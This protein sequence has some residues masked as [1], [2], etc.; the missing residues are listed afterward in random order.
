MA[1]A[2]CVFVCYLAALS[3]SRINSVDDRMIADHSGCEV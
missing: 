3:V 2:Q 1:Q